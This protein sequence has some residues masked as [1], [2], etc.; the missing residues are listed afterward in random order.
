MNIMKTS[1]FTKLSKIGLIIFLFFLIS[2][3]V[4]ACE[5]CNRIF[6][7]GLLDESKYNSLVSKE[8]RAAI[9][10]QSGKDNSSAN[11]INDVLAMNDLTVSDIDPKAL[12]AMLS[13]HSE[14]GMSALPAGASDMQDFKGVQF[15]DIMQRDKNLPLPAT[16]FVPQD[17]K[18]DKHFRLTLE[19]S[20]TY[21]GNGV[22]YKGFTVND[23]IPGP[24]VV[25]QEGDI[26]S[27]TFVNKGNITH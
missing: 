2:P 23:R 6:L 21:I 5:A 25:V 19:E 4:S 26:V 20:D 12:T 17:T 14:S 16:S 22:I 13:N 9:A 7:D 10:A 8:L 24:T 27:L 15:D 3:D 11:W 1:L 18:A